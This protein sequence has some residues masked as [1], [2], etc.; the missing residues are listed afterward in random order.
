MDRMA[1]MSMGIFA[2]LLSLILLGP[3]APAVLAQ[4]SLLQ[5]FSYLK[6]GR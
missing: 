4:Y 2:A 5:A 1:Q 6:I 3:G